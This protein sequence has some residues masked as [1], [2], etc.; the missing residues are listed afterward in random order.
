MS[1]EYATTLLWQQDT[2]PKTKFAILKVAILKELSA[3]YELVVGR[4]GK[5]GGTLKSDYVKAISD[6][7][8]EM[9]DFA[10]VTN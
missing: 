8:G 4:M 9:I 1:I 7:V 3:R 10:T 6:F 5:K 2:V